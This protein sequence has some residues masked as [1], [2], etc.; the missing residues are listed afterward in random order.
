MTHF[1]RTHYNKKVIFTNLGN[2]YYLLQK[3]FKH[4][5]KDNKHHICFHK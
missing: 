5:I 2:V 4:V 1:V 3:T